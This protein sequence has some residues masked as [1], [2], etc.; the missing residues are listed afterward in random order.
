MLDTLDAAAVRRWCA[1]GLAALK[2]HQ[3][4]IDGLNVYPVPDGDTGTNLVLTLTSAQQALAMDLDT[5]A[6]GASTAHGHALRLMARGALLGARGNSGVILSQILRGLAD[7]LATAPAV[8]GRELAAALREASDAA[9]AAVARPVEGT[10]LSVVS[11][12][13]GAAQRTGSDELRTVARAAAGAAATALDRTPE[14]LPA[15]A[16]AG[17]VDAGG[18]GLCL[19]L[20][21][22]VEVITGESPER[23]APAPRA[24]PSPAAAVR[25]AGSTDYA[26]EVQFLLDA[27]PDAVRELRDVLAALGDSLV[28]VGDGNASGGTWQVH[29]HVNDVGAAIEAGVVA[30]R[31]HQI[32]VTRFADQPAPQPVPATDGRAAVVVAAGA[33]IA[34]LLAG[35]GAVVVPGNPSTGELLDAVRATGAAR[36]V[37]LPNDPDAQAVANQV[38]EEAH[39]LGV[40]VAVVP[41]RS[42]V[43]ALAALAVRDPR[44]RFADDV[45]AMAEAAGACRYAEV[46]QAAREAL[47]VAGPC[48]AG[49]VLALV[50]G[51]VHL[52]GTELVDTCVALVDR[53]LGGGGEL[54]TLLVGA[55]APDGLADAV[56]THI[57]GHWPFVE[58]QAYPGGQPHHP[59]L[60]GVE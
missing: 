4:E 17:V 53:M 27:E 13:A 40:E 47:T 59:L 14:Q 38:A 56:R 33:G 8:R 50:E 16:H 5:H 35:E 22:L 48:R 42:P 29:V 25:E 54:V 46:C 52:I 12:A 7:A 39:R 18:R 3:G 15:L 32:S 37:V 55:D 30:G 34:E 24:V 60:V 41:T 23:P 43:Q 44:R 10:L 36:V 31:P 6:D 9:Y 28:V 11:A 21:A 19:L 57:A 58:V 51:E 2:R 49:D 20:D 1:S 45:I 26:Y